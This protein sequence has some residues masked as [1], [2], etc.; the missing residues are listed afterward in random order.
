M[1]KTSVMLII[2]ILIF[3]MIMSVLV[4]DSPNSNSIKKSKND[5]PA[6]KD[7]L[8]D[9]ESYTQSVYTEL[10]EISCS[11]KVEITPLKSISS[12]QSGI[13]YDSVEYHLLNFTYNKVYQSQSHQED[14]HG[15]IQYNL[16]QT[17]TTTVFASMPVILAIYRNTSVNTNDRTQIITQALIDANYEAN[18]G[19]SIDFDLE[20]F[21]KAQILGI[22]PVIGPN[23][24]NLLFDKNWIFNTPMNGQAVLGKVGVS[25]P[26]AIPLLNIG[27]S[28]G[29]KID[30]DF[31]AIV[32]SDDYG[33]DI[34]NHFLN[35]DTDGAIQAFSIEVPEFFS[36]DLVTTDL[37]NFDM[38]FML[39]L[40]FYL[41]IT[42]GLPIFNLP[43][44]FPIFSFPVAKNHLQTEN[45]DAINLGTDVN[46]SND[47]PFVYGVAYNYSD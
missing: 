47:L 36:Q 35:W 9:Q 27:I 15:I 29:P 13:K 5:I 46:P 30:T 11:N 6:N 16:N 21:F 3:S 20:Y 1:K 45:I 4:I 23:A 34:S 26:A 18:M 39:S 33:I 25:F 31:T 24:G 7:N 22:G 28:V 42:I 44:H 32:K 8:L 19:F 17:I 12:I 2:S 14:N 38:E 43:F 10:E 37:F 41:D 40:V